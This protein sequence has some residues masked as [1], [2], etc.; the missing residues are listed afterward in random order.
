MEAEKWG[1]TEWGFYR[2]TNVQILN[3]LEYKGRELF[4]EK[5]NLTI[6]S[7]LGIILRILSYVIDMLFAA[8]ENVYNSRYADTAVG[9][10]LYNL[11]RNI[12]LTLLPAGKARGYITITGE[13]GTIVRTGYLVGTPG[14]LHYTVMQECSIG[15]DGKVLALIQAVEAGKEYNTEAGTVTSIVNPESIQGIE[16]IYNEAAI[17]NG[18]ERETDAEYRERYYASVDY[19]G[20]VNSDSIRAALMQEVDGLHT[21]YVYENDSDVRDEEYG[22]PPHSI[23]AVVYGGLDEDIARVI[24][25]EKA[26]GIQTVGSSEIQILSKS[27]QK[28]G[29]HFSR[30][31][32]VEIYIKITGLKT[33]DKFEGND[34]IICA[35]M[36]YVG[37]DAL[38]GLS[39]GKDVIYISL[40]G[41]IMDVAGVVDFDVYIGKTAETTQKENISIGI[42]EKAF[43]GKEMVIFN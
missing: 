10:S 32:L 43:T 8:L 24:Y 42:R 23:E 36:E 15:T 3:A 1:L 41:V 16:S 14:G 13:P 17:E 5:V 37:S 7:P 25:K 28:I 2:P 29:I 22:L 21:A 35:L 18:R 4:G 30:A 40:P 6:R 12:G 39:I 33:D 31:E 20:G 38:G 26:A 34:E 11:G 19:A 9:T 27:D